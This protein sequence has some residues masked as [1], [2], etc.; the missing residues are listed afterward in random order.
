LKNLEK[1][2]KLIQSDAKRLAERYEEIYDKQQELSANCQD[3]IRQANIKIPNNNIADAEFKEN[4]NKINEATKNLSQTLQRVK[5][6]IKKQQ[7]HISKYTKETENKKI[8]LPAKPENLI[9]E[10]LSE[11]TSEIDSQIKDIKRINNV[12]NL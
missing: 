7:F 12:I 11:I 4:V 8:M 5:G 1:E 9:R 6:N 3:L 2:K 10:I